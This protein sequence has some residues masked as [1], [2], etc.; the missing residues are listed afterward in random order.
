MYNY[1]FLTTLSNSTKNN[2]YNENEMKNEND[3]IIQKF[4]GS[5]CKGSL[6]MSLSFYWINEHFNDFKYVIYHQADVYLNIMELLKYIELNEIE[7][8][9]FKLY[10]EKR[11]TNQNKLHYVPSSFYDKKILPPYPRGPLFIVN[12]RIIRLIV[13]T[14]A[15][16][17]KIIL[18]DDM[19]IG[20]TILNKNISTADFRKLTLF[21]NPSKPIS[22][23]CD[24]IC[25]KIYFHGLTI[26]E[27]FLLNLKMEICEK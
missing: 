23:N 21:Y 3:I 27:V 7:L 17:S 10:K 22:L 15:T 12:K 24:F 4:K 2:K 1:C 18:I 11:I 5:Y 19:L 14:L 25:K 9:G 8:S 6:Q 13:N 16:S 20:F 26:G